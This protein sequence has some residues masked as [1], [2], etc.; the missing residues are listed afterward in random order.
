[1]MKKITLLV[2]S[3]FLLLWIGCAPVNK[4]LEKANEGAQEV[5]KTA[6]KASRIP[7]SA[8]EGAAEGYGGEEKNNPYNR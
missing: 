8:T 7:T 5:G 2:I 4:G 1:M 6:G 3:F